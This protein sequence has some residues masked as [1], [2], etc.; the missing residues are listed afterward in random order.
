MVVGVE[1]NLRWPFLL[2]LTLLRKSRLQT[3]SSQFK[4]FL[5]P[6]NAF[7][8]QVAAWTGTNK[9]SR[10][11]LPVACLPPICCLLTEADLI[12]SN[13]QNATCYLSAGTNSKGYCISG[14]KGATGWETLCMCACVCMHV[15]MYWKGRHSSN[16]ENVSGRKTRQLT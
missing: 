3:N 4:S 1:L 8:E 16:H 15:P 14:V 10:I 12:N 13:C 6:C 9:E 5:Y 7:P 11:Y 2:I